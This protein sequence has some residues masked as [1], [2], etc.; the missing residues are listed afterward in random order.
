M[1]MYTFFSCAAAA[2]SHD[3]YNCD[4]TGFIQCISD[5]ELC[6]RTEDCYI[7]IYTMTGTKINFTLSIIVIPTLGGADAILTLTLLV[8]SCLV[9]PYYSNRLNVSEILF[10]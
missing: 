1:Y 6:D 10:A 3:Y 5:D 7:Y 4:D 9:Q 8:N 2:C